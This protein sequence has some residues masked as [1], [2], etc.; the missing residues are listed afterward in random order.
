MLEW[1]QKLHGSMVTASRFAG[2]SQPDLAARD[3]P[4]ARQEPD[5]PSESIITSNGN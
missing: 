3:L 2:L 1:R 4:K 5:E